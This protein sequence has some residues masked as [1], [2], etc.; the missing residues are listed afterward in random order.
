MNMQTVL[1]AEIEEKFN[2]L[3]SI[4][5]GSTQQQNQL[6]S[7]PNLIDKTIEI[8]KLNTTEEQNKAQM[9][10]ER[11]SRLVKNCIDVGSIVLPLIVTIWGTKATFKFEETGSITTSV[12]RKFIDK[13]ISWKK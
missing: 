13:I 10:E 5:P 7:H 8:E 2:S 9:I 4:D 1:E 3:A 12:G 6:D 11:K